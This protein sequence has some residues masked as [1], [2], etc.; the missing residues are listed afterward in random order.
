MGYQT[1]EKTIRQ[2]FPEVWVAPALVIGGTDSRHYVKSTNNIY[3][4]AAL[5]LGPDDLR[6]VHGINERVSVAD[7][8]GCVKFYYQ[9]IKN[10]AQ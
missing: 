4:F 8:A 5:R 1:I 7:F 9:L 3:R 6:R 2:L 10:S